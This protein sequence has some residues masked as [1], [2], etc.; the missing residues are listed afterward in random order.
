MLL[1]EQSGYSHLSNEDMI[2]AT[3]N[4]GARWRSAALAK[5]NPKVTLEMRNAVGPLS[6]FLAC[7][8]GYQRYSALTGAS[9]T[10]LAESAALSRC[11]W[12]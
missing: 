1:Y 9:Q 2:P 7:D 5:R 12:S 3:A 4:I 11:D 10:S 8:E 6:S